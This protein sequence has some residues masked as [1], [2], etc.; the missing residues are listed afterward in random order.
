M[1]PPDAAPARAASK[2]R[3]VSVVVVTVYR[4]AAADADRQRQ[5]LM[6]ASFSRPSFLIF[7]AYEFLNMLEQAG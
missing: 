5:R 4:P 3:H 7:R 6:P 2:C 1:F